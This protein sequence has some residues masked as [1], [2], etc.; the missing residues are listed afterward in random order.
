MLHDT[1]AVKFNSCD[2]Q[3][4]KRFYG[5][6]GQIRSVCVTKVKETRSRG[7]SIWDIFHINTWKSSRHK[8]EIPIS[9][10]H[11]D[12]VCWELLGVYPSV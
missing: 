10:K 6:H 7:E 8:G 4:G 12:D 11:A 5:A 3:H 2:S 9:E 1:A